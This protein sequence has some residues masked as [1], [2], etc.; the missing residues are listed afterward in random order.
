MIRKLKVKFI[1]LSMTSLFV[2]LAF[3]VAGM[4]IV[5]YNSIIEEADTILSLFSKNKEAF[6]EMGD[7]H[8]KKLPPNLSPETPYESR[9]FTVFYN[10][11]NTV[12]NVDV[13]KIASVDKSTAV[14]YAEDILYGKKNHGFIGEFRYIVNRDFNSTRITFLDC[15]RKLDSFHSFLINSIAMSMLGYAVVFFIIF[16]MSDRIIKPIAESYEK[17]KRFITDAGH[18]IKTPLTIISANTDLLEMELGEDHES[19]VDIKEQTK[20]LRMLTDNL[21]LLTRMEESESNMPKIEFPLSEVVLETANAFRALAIS[22]KKEFICNIEPILTLN[23]NDKA[24]RQLVSI[25]LDNA[26]KYSPLEGTVTVSLEKKNRTIILSTF[27]TTETEVNGEQ[28]QYVFDRFY[29]IENSRNSGTGGHGI[30][31]SVAKAIVTAHNGKISA[32][33]KGG[34]TFLITATFPL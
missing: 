15:R 11:M 30:G 22:Q 20:Q 31:L 25:L 28:L 23:G 4:N 13:S 8:D 32:S 34:K 9:Y 1:I 10:E 29:R 3:I 14:K 18:E 33:T 17:Q 26:L 21:V 19:L 24:I 7:R 12:V 6:P 2:L 27:N 5:N 16:I